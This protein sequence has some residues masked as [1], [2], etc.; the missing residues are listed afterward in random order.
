M[1]RFPHL[2]QRLFNV[3]LALHPAKAEVVIAALADRLGVARLFHTPF[4]P[5]AFDEDY[6]RFSSPARDDGKPYDVVQGIAILQVSG[7]LVQRLGCMRPY[8]GMTGYD[9]L[10]ACFADAMA[11]QAVRAVV[12]D[13]DSPGGEVAGCFDLVDT[14][15]AARGRKPIWAILNECAFSAGYALACAADRITIPRT[16]AAGSVGVIVVMAEMSRALTEAGITVNILQF[17]AR[18]ADGHPAIPL[19]DPARDRFQAA[20]D[21]LGKLFVGTVAKYRGLD[22]G[23]VRDMEAADFLGADAVRAGLADAVAAPDEAFRALLSSL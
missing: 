2:A 3:P 19:S 1:T 17:G 13:I 23:N 18:K 7:T 14:M 21:T 11:D 12:L 6:A 5:T 4:S 8:S 22:P 20:V 10:R 9:G 15:A 16:G